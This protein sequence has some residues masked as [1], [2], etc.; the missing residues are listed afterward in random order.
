MSFFINL[1]C[2]LKE[3]YQTI[4]R[5]STVRPYSLFQFRCL[6]IKIAYRRYISIAGMYLFTK[7]IDG[8]SYLKDVTLFLSWVILAITSRKA[9]AF[10]WLS[11]C[12]RYLTTGS[13]KSVGSETLRGQNAFIRYYQYIYLLTQILTKLI[14]YQLCIEITMNSF[15]IKLFTVVKS[16][17]SKY[18][19]NYCLFEILQPFYSFLNIPAE[20]CTLLPFN[21]FGRLLFILLSFIVIFLFKKLL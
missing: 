13:T 6:L 3:S 21:L 18:T 5:S 20:Y 19:N 11:T 16:I 2:W 17:A 10:C 1:N 8:S 12:S 15:L 14:I 7:S 4:L 9:K